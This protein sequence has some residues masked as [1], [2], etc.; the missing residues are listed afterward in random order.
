MKKL[1]T[2]LATVV[3]ITGSI[4]SIT[5]AIHQNNKIPASYIDP[6]TPNKAQQEANQINYDSVTLNDT[7][8]KSYLNTTAEQDKTVIEQ[9]LEANKQLDPKTAG[10]FT[11]DNTTSLQWYVK[12]RISYETQASDGSKGRGVLDIYVN[13]YTPSPTPHKKASSL[14]PS[15]PKASIIGP[16]TKK[17]ETAA[18]IANKLRGKIIKLDP[19]A[20]LGRNIKKYSND[21]N[22]LIV[23]AGF[24]TAPEAKD[25]SWNSKTIASASWYWTVNFTVNVNGQTASGSDTINA[26]TG[27]TTDQI[28]A[29]LKAHP[30]KLNYNYWNK[31]D[32]K[33]N[34]TQLRSII[35]NEGI[36]TKAEASVITGLS[37]WDSLYTVDHTWIGRD[38][39]IDYIVN[40]N[41]TVSNTPDNLGAQVLNDGKDAQQL[42]NQIA[43][44]TYIHVPHRDNDKYA[45]NPIVLADI[46][47]GLIARGYYNA[48][49]L[50]YLHTPHQFLQINFSNPNRVSFIFQKDGQIAKTMP[51]IIFILV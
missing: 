42:A 1:I 45:D 26:T 3:L 7:A 4:T 28:A 40:D 22:A 10:D 5:A 29:K 25:V 27:E 18:E 8:T 24:L 33:T 20:W 12:N 19:T 21:L 30:V 14:T 2:T 34:L 48:S 43:F 23:K 39:Y 50:K 11:F 37:G 15:D 35:V 38:N 47:Q 36:L 32:L 49:Q 9:Q 31:K 51:C 16:S 41:N 44:S 17:K 46:K 13:P 6:S